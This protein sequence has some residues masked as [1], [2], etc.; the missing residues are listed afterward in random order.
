MHRQAAA[1]MN[2]P[3]YNYNHGNPS[4][5]MFHPQQMHHHQHQHHQQHH[6]QQP[7]PF[8]MMAP[9][10]E[11]GGIIA[12]DLR[13][14]RSMADTIPNTDIEMGDSNMIDSTYMDPQHDYSGGFSQALHSSPGDSSVPAQHQHHAFGAYDGSQAY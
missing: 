4:A 3:Q 1:Q 7:Q 8:A 6:H 9:P 14:L 13:N 12:D 10:E 2:A 11:A 5:S